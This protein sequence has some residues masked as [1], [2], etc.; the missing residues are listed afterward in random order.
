MNNIHLC[1]EILIGLCFALAFFS[2]YVE[3]IQSKVEYLTKSILLE[4]LKVSKSR[5]FNYDK[6]NAYIK[7][8]GVS[9]MMSESINPVMFII[10]KTLV[11]LG[12]AVLVMTQVQSILLAVVFFVI[13]FWIVDVLVRMN[14]RND[15]D[16]M[17]LD[18]SNVYDIL[19]IQMK[20]GVYITDSLYF[21]YKDCKNKRLKDGFLELYLDI[22]SSN[23]IVEALRNFESKF[24]NINI[25]TLCA[26]LEQ[27]LVTGQS[28]EMLDNIT[29]KIVSIQKLVNEQYKRKIENKFHRLTVF[30]VLGIFAVMLIV[31]QSDFTSALSQF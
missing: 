25:S 31:I 22:Q 28:A 27:S 26:V 21:C 11:G 13:G 12:F 10:I 14:N 4:R 2:C 15:N 23:N 7:G 6:L 16:A 24:N 20:A 17:M 18:I 19:K 3:P 29:K 5:Y 1:I 30:I 9:Y 8:Y